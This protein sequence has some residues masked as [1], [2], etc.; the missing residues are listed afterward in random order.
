M[1][2][3]IH[4]RA[5]RRVDGKWEVIP[6]LAP[7]DWRSY[8]MYGF[9][10]N[11][12]NYSDVPPIAEARGLP[13]DYPKTAH[14]DEDNYD[15]LGDH[16]YSWLSVEEL[17]AFN[18]DAKVEDRR[19]TVQ[20]APN[21]WNGGATADPGGGAMTTYREF[22]GKAFFEDLEKLKAEGAER[23]VFGFDS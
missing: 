8:G 9:L 19:I 5:E 1:G 22:L 6:G 16:S 7:F 10:A 18:Y 17:L 2:C 11:V 20:V 12:R 21:C 13:K 4:S 15:G 23:I 14:S 3:D